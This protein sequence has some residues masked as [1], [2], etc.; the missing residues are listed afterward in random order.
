MTR[1]RS[2]VD[3]ELRKHAKVVLASKATA[4]MSSIMGRSSPLSSLAKRL[5][6]VEEGMWWARWRR[7]TSKVATKP[8]SS[9]RASRVAATRAAAGCARC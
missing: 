9:S 6:Q 8:R 2:V 7:R 1:T 4:V 5:D 3:Q